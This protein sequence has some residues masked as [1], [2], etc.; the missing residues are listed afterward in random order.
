MHDPDGDQPSSQLSS[1]QLSFWDAWDVNTPGSPTTPPSWEEQQNPH[2]Y[3]ADAGCW[4][5]DWDDGETTEPWL[6]ANAAS[7]RY[8]E[9]IRDDGEDN[10]LLASKPQCTPRIDWEAWGTDV[11]RETLDA[12]PD[13]HASDGSWEEWLGGHGQMPQETGAT[14]NHGS[15]EGK[16]EHAMIAQLTCSVPQDDWLG[17]EMMDQ[18]QHAVL[19]EGDTDNID[20]MAG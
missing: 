20:W 4:E 11:S 2:V 7:V 6:G 3:G 17:A 9:E 19:V 18:G 10:Q 1:S 12:E 14:A 16:C 8:W 5:D 13:G 15:E